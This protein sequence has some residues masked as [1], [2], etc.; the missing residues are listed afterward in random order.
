MKFFIDSANID[1]IKEANAL[2]LLD[3]VTTNPTLISK[4]GKT[5]DEVAKS[6]CQ[7][8]KGPVSLEVVSLNWEEMIS[9]GRALR[10][11]GENVVVKIPM[12]ADGLKAVKQLTA[13]GIPTNVTLI[14]QAVQALL[15]AKAG[16]TYVSPF[17]GRHD[18]IAEDGMLLAQDILTIFRAYGY[19]TQ[20]L[21]ASVRHSLHVL[22]AAKMGADVV[23]VP[24][25]VIQ[26]LTKHPL[27]D[28]GLKS[29]L[30]DWKS[31]KK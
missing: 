6:I 11:Y 13:E 9:E 30:D 20:C 8:V 28:L 7:L 4:S 21:V 18:D 15:A 27:T 10:K 12:T 17:V 24:L 22:Q 29:F 2:G 25:K 1:E 31:V 26:G 19:K 5:F 23:T 16:A 3:G 14:F